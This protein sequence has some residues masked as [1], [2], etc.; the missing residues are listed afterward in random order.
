MK[1]ANNLRFI[2]PLSGQDACQGDS[3]G[4]LFSVRRN[5]SEALDRYE[6]I[7]VTS[8]G[9]KCGEIG[10]PGTKYKLQRDTSGCSPSYVDTK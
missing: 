8:F 5:S 9:D 10:S 1:F 7:G 6:V 2:S 3:G 4:P